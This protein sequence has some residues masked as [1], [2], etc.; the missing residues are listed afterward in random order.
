MARPRKPTHLKLVAGTYRPDRSNPGEPAPIVDL[1]ATPA[2]LSERAAAIFREVVLI[3]DE[4]GL[5][6][7]SDGAMLA[8]VALRLEEVEIT[9]ALIE[10]SGRMYLSKVVRDDTGAIVAQQQK[11]HPAVAQRNEAMRHA[12]SLLH[13]FGLSPASRSRVTACAKTPGRNPFDDF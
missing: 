4:M 1:P 11:S 6:S 7:R 9:T 8:L 13:E 2:W 3:L 5:A 12:Q 10:D